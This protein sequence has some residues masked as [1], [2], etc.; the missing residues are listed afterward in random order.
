MTSLKKKLKRQK[1]KETKKDL[2]QKVGL[3][4]K[5]S[6]YCLTCGKNFDKTNKDMVVTWNVVV[7]QDTVRLYCPQCWNNAHQ[8]IQ[9]I[10]NGYSN[11][12]GD[13]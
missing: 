9:E 11:T 8:L 4:N 13:V 7:A 2:T 3:F 6:D 1:I 10:K 5:I 12:K